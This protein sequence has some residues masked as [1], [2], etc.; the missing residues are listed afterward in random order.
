M[1]SVLWFVVF[2]IIPISLYFVYFTIVYRLSRHWRKGS[3]P[4]WKM[5]QEK[6]LFV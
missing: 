2:S 6:W 3:L 1:L 4:W 5:D